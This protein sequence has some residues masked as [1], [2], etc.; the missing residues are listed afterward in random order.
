MELHILSGGAAQGVV[1]DLQQDFLD[2]T[3][4]RLQATFGAVGMMKDKLLG[5]TP[6]DV[7][8]LTQALID[9]LEKSGRVEPGSAAPPLRI[10]NSMC[11][12]LI[13]DLSRCLRTSGQHL[14]YAFRGDR[15]RA[16]AQSQRTG[17]RIAYGCGGRA[18]R[19]FASAEG[20]AVAGND[21]D[22]DCRHFG[23]AQH[24]VA[25]PAVAGNALAV[26]AHRFL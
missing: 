15:Q 3:G 17:H 8:I 11:S 21:A 19:R 12:P 16:H 23:E 2:Q 20:R 9:E 18:E 1:R 13:D 10:C 24:R 7:L 4:A 6:C 5:G 22:I 25:V 14:L 26:E